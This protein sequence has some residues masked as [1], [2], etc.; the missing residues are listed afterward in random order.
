MTERIG[1]FGGTFDP[2]HHGHLILA[3]DAVEQLGLTRLIF[4]PA[5]INPHKT[6]RPAAPDAARLEMLRAANAGEPAF[7][8]DDCELR[9]AGPSFTIDTVRALQAR[10]QQQQPAATTAG[11]WI[12]LIGADNVPDLPAW[13]RIDALRALVRFAV[14]ARG[15]NDEADALLAT[16][17]ALPADACHL[18]TRR[19]DVSAT[20]I[21]NRVAAGRTIR[22][23]VPE[24]VAAIIAAQRLYLSPSSPSEGVPPSPTN[25]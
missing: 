6:H 8:V 3:R 10:W 11:E 1:I 2:V 23:L 21:R 13:H 16:Q 12:L 24:A 25:T 5:A 20:E 15:E 18:R 4:V 9:R 7:V 14:F 17:P 19:L 22:Y